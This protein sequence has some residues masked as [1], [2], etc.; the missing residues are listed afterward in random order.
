MGSSTETI[1]TPNPNPDHGEDGFS[2]TPKVQKGTGSL[3]QRMYGTL[4]T[5]SL[6]TVPCVI[7]RSPS[8][9]Q[10]RVRIRVSPIIS[11]IT[12]TLTIILNAALTITVTL[13]LNLTLTIQF[14]FRFSDEDTFKK[15]LSFDVNVTAG[16]ENND[17]AGVSGRKM[18]YSVSLDSYSVGTDDICTEELIFGR[19]K[20]RNNKNRLN[21]FVGGRIAL[22]RALK[23]INEG[24]SPSI[25]TGD[26]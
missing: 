8:P 26:D 4:N 16:S 25:L 22:R 6:C 1:A 7:L 15:S 3:V 10:V 18:D 12:L 23:L 2:T 17:I 14:M 21:K 13:T 24:E 9:E 20:E 19:I 5:I 11:N